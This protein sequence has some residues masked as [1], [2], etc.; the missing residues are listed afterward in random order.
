MRYK[1]PKEFIL[2]WNLNLIHVIFA[3]FVCDWKCLIQ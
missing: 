1:V 3:G 2:G